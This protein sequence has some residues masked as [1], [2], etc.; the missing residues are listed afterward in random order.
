MLEGKL[1][2]CSNGL[3]NNNFL[4]TPLEAITFFDKCL[5]GGKHP[6]NLILL[7]QTYLTGFISTSLIVN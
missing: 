7:R 3:D 4:P 2:S 6:S 1:E 5:H